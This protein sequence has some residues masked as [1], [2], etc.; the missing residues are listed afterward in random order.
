M[1]KRTRAAIGRPR[2]IPPGGRLLRPRFLERL[3]AALRALDQR[4]IVEALL[5]VELHAARAAAIGVDRHFFPRNCPRTS[6]DYSA[7]PR[8][9]KDPQ[10]EPICA[11]ARTLPWP[12][13][14]AAVRRS[15]SRDPLA[16]M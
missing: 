9:C 15:T 16:G 4:R 13:G 6:R 8:A 14:L 10:G 1:T 3:L 11:S 12:A 7:A 2:F 5:S